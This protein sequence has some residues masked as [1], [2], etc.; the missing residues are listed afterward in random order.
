MG[1]REL[2]GFF[3]VVVHGARR[4]GVLALRMSFGPQPLDKC[5]F[6]F[7]VSPLSVQLKIFRKI[8]PSVTKV[9]LAIC[10]VPDVPA[11]PPSLPGFPL[12]PCRPQTVLQPLAL[13]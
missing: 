1:G 9:Y 5:F 3:E 4:I 6:D 8:I 13:H 7:S 11:F 2:K 10:T 12:S